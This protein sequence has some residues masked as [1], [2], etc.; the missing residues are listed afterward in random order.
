MTAHAAPFNWT[1][2]TNGNWATGTNWAEGLP[3]SATTT[4]LIFNNATQLTTSNNISGGLTLNSLTLTAN[5]GKRVLSGN[6]L[7]FDGTAPTL[8]MVNTVGATADDDTIINTP[9]QMNQTLSITGG[10]DFTHQLLFGTT[11]VFSGTGGLTW[12]GGIGFISAT[13]TYSGPT[14]ITAGLLGVNKNGAFGSS[15]GVTVQSGGALQLQGNTVINKPLMLAGMGTEDLPAFNATGVTASAKSWQGSVALAAD[16]SI[17]AINGASLSISGVISGTANLS[18]LNSADGK[19]SLFSPTGNTFVGSVIASRGRLHLFDDNELGPVTNHLTLQD[20]ITISGPV[21][22]AGRQVTSGVGGFITEVLEIDSSIDGPGSVTVEGSTLTGNN[23]FTGGLFVKSSNPTKGGVAYI[24]SEASL[25]VA[26]GLVQIENNGLLGFLSGFTVPSARPMIASGATANLVASGAITVTVASNITGA[27]RV[28]IGPIGGVPNVLDTGTIRLTG[29]NTNAGGLAVLGSTVEISSDAQIGGPSGVLEIGRTVDFDYFPGVLRAIG[30]LN[31]AAPRSTTFRE[32]TVDTNGFDVT[33]NQ[34]LSGTGL[35]KAGAGV[36]RLNSAIT[37]ADSIVQVTGGILRLGVNDALGPQGIVTL[38]AGAALEL[39]DFNLGLSNLS[40]AGE[41]RLGTGTLTLNSIS[42]IGPITGTGGIVID[43]LNITSPSDL[44]GINTFTGGLTIRG[45]A[46]VS[47]T[48]ETNLGGAGNVILLDNGGL[49]YSGI[50][51]IVLGSSVSFDV[52]AGGARFSTQQESLSIS[53]QLTGTGPVSFSGG[54]L[55]GSGFG[56]YE[57][58]LT[59]P[60]NTFT[61]NIGFSGEG[62]FGIVADG[63]LGNAA[64]IVTLGG[65]VF[66]GESFRPKQGGLRAYAN[67]T[68]PATRAIHLDGDYEGGF[69]D[70]NGFNVTI[71]G[72]ITEVTADI[73]FVKDGAGTLFINGANTMTGT[74][75]V[76][77]GTLGGTGIIGL[78]EVTGTATLA[79]GQS[80]GTLHTRDVSLGHG[81]T[82]GLEFASATLA[83]QLDVTGTVTLNGSVHL[84]PTLGYTPATS[85][86]FIIIANDDTDPVA[87]VLT[88]SGTPLDEGAVFTFGGASWTISYIGGTGNDVTLTVAPASTPTLAFTSFSI[89]PPAGGGSGKQAQGS[90]RG[91][92]GAAVRLERSSN[93]ID[94]TLL[95]TITLNGAGVGTFDVTDPLATDL[96][97]YHLIFP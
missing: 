9:I 16:T 60:N 26:G 11:A 67:L 24:G 18:I 48:S 88:F 27:G 46:S 13:N 23:T 25:G 72:V 85:A 71:N 40:G 78:L 41:V 44:G 68:L 30:N 2:T 42:S 84:A 22:P 59:N 32:G 50:T 69:I 58:R 79:P 77:A 35:T 73:P 3:A 96:A 15:T 57:V 92:P 31:V 93:L 75:T 21:L 47:F 1:G 8:T 5:S 90:I 39:N 95:D 12:A 34:T 14:I 54:S 52:A 87:G 51:P 80:A 43:S 6:K 37:S 76:L 63:S 83:G 64:N 10:V 28:E 97:F 7:T 65:N 33:F 91:T 4:A 49:V 81:T 94:W 74:T 29:T 62:S 55:P 53:G 19:V 82:L 66:D 70:T 89:A 17:G 61:G 36:L 38:S 20:G 86:T 56:K 45:K